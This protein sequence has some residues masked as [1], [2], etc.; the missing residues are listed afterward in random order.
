MESSLRFRVGADLT[1]AQRSIVGFASRIGAGLAGAFSIGAA[2][3]LAKGFVQAGAEME[4]FE[5]RLTVLMGSATEARARMAELFEF[6]A[7]T[8]FEVSQ[9]VAAETTL[10]GFGA[11]AEELMPG[12]IDFAATT[13]ADLSQAAIDIGKAWSQGATGLESDFGRVL[14]KQVEL[15]EGTNAATMDLEDFRVALTETLNQG[16]FAGGAERLSRT[17]A[18]MVSNLQDEWSRFQIQVSDAGLFNNVKAVLGQT[19]DL[20]AQHRDEI[21]SLAST[22]STVLWQSFVGVGTVIAVGLDGLKAWEVATYAVMGAATALGD[23]FLQAT[24]PLR[25]AAILTADAL[26]MPR[27]TQAALAA[28]AKMLDI[29]RSLQAAQKDAVAFVQSF[30]PNASKLEDFRKFVADAEAMAAQLEPEAATGRTMKPAGATGGDGKGAAD[31]YAADLAAAEAF[32]E[33]LRQLQLDDFQQAEELRARDSIRLSDAYEA[34]LVTHEQALADNQLVWK[35]YYDT[36]AELTAESNRV[37]EQ[38][39]QEEMRRIEAERQERISMLYAQLDAASAVFTTI[40]GLIEGE[41]ERAKNA[42]KAWAYA[43]IAIDTAVGIQ[44]AFAQYGWPWGIL[45]AAAVTASGVAQAVA[46]SR[47][48]QGG[49]FAIGDPAPD[50][51]DVVIGG[52]RRRVLA[53][54]QAVVLNSQ[55]ARAAEAQNASNGAGMGGTS[56]EL[57][58]GRVTQREM[59]RAEERAGTILRRMVRSVTNYGLAPGWSGAAPVA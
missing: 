1:D 10:R 14:R 41:S 36:V 9:I 40:S 24:Q 43:S 20:I 28:D 39:H 55:A 53:Q 6:A 8:P 44:K 22:V 58:V 5:S 27:V 3:A 23:V 17:F 18:G 33:E 19:L 42:Q 37:L 11:A 15:R 57:T 16:V 4:T 25:D 50:E 54:E 48:H 32:H 26:G 56:I 45:P 2:G 52:R 7:S 31:K 49:S 59:F 34:G 13:G 35:R 38:A 21:K 30:D 29:R 12:L 51:R 46:V 47:A